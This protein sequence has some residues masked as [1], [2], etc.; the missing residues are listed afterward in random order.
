MVNGS[1]NDQMRRNLLVALS[2]AFAILLLSRA[3][4]AV[5]NDSCTAAPTTAD[6]RVSI[7]LKGGQTVF[8][9]GEAIS[10]AMSTTATAPRRYWINSSGANAYCIEPAAPDPMEAH[11][12]RRMMQVG[13]G[14]FNEWELSNNPYLAE[15]TLNL[16]FKLAPG[17]YVFYVVSMGI[18]HP[19]AA[20]ELEGGKQPED[21]HISDVVRSNK[22]E[23]D[24]R[25]ASAEWQHQQVE[26]AVATLTSHSSM[27]ELQRAAVVLRI[28]DTKESTRALVRILGTP[29]PCEWADGELMDGLYSSSHHQLAIDSMRKEMAEPGTAVSTNFLWTLVELQ[30]DSDGL[31]EDSVADWSQPNALAERWKRESEEEEALM[32]TAVE[33]AA[34]ALPRKQGVARAITLIAVMQEAGK[35]TALLQSLRPALIASWKDLPLGRQDELLGF[36]WQ[37]I[38]GPE[39]LPVLRSIVA[40]PPK[41]ARWPETRNMALRRIYELDPDEGSRL[42]LR[43]LM[44]ADSNPTIELVRHLS[45]EGIIE[46]VPAAVERIGKGQGRAL[47]FDLLDRYAGPEA[48]GTIERI[49]AKGIGKADCNPQA[50][51][52]RY[53]LRVA[54]EYGAEQVRAAMAARKDAG[55]WCYNTLLH[56][57][58]DQ[59]PA[60][61]QIAIDAL[62]DDEAEVERNAASALGNWGTADAEAP[63]WERLQRLHDE[64]AGRPQELRRLPGLDNPGTTAIEMEQA[65]ADA[66]ARGRAWM[67]R[68]ED[69]TRLQALLLTENERRQISFAKFDLDK[70]PITIVPT[71][72]GDREPT[73]QMLQYLEL[74]ENQLAAKLSQLPRGTKFYWQMIQAEQMPDPVSLSTQ[75]AE[76][77]KMR[78]LAAGSGQEITQA[79]QP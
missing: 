13:G 47:D 10:L 76:F 30:E 28:L 42:I 23:F 36:R 21:G 6:V 61:Q 27:D 7:A 34:A 56:D 40:Q 46:G 71:W 5:E 75:Q 24:V 49:L 79:A 35:D 19:A 20:G 22:I 43:E 25:P 55:T 41:E 39:M 73:F 74:T 18:W 57:L 37:L 4:W 63:L 54:P 14:L 16:R 69:F 44:N 50:K 51:M 2:A 64:W 12:K 78:A 26:K 29:G 66:I 62:D 70:N 8:Q 32:K 59:L 68:P 72:N 65:L 9:Q 3:C 67:S 52:L 60:V 48:L 15:G 45:P 77:E 53:A 31:D 33:E 11:D 17:H 38:G 58:G 1:S